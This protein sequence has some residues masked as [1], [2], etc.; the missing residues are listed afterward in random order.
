MIN[1]SPKSKSM[2]KTYFRSLE[3]ID[4]DNFSDQMID[5]KSDF[6]KLQ[7]LQFPEFS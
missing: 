2:E 1:D 3:I 6:E 5:H 4:K 7:E